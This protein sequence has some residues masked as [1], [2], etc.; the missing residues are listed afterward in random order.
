MSE[1]GETVIKS[2]DIKGDDSEL[3]DI[4]P[5]TTNNAAEQKAE[6]DDVANERGDGHEEEQEGG[7]TE[8]QEK[9]HGEKHEEE[10][11]QE[12]DAAAQLQN[13]A[14]EDQDEDD[15]EDQEND[16]EEV[17]RCLC[18]LAQPPDPDNQGYIQCD[19]CAV[20]QHQ[21]CLGISPEKGEE[22]EKYW[23]EQCKPELHTVYDLKVNRRLA[24]KEPGDSLKRSSYN[25]ELQKQTIYVEKRRRHNRNILSNSAENSPADENDPNED[26][27]D[28]DKSLNKRSLGRMSRKRGKT[29]SIRS[30]SKDSSLR[31]SRNRSS[32]A[33]REEMEYQNILNKVLQESKKDA[34]KDAY[35]NEIVG[36]EPETYSE[37][38]EKTTEHR[39]TKRRRVASPKPEQ[40]YAFED[41]QQEEQSQSPQPKR[42][43]RRNT[44]KETE[45]IDE[46]MEKDNADHSKPEEDEINIELS[47]VVKP[48]R[49]YNR[50]APGAPSSNGKKN[51]TRSRGKQALNDNEN[52]SNSQKNEEL[53][54]NQ[55]QQSHMDKLLQLAQELSK[56]R[57]TPEGITIQEMVQRSSAM[58]EF[59]GR[60]T[61]ELKSLSKQQ[62]A[63]LSFVENEQFINEYHRDVNISETLKH[64]DKLTRDLM[65][66]QQSK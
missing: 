17:T 63:L 62:S 37:D 60:S 57:T 53:L 1:T 65:S 48:K 38:P 27:I 14:Q 35:G 50:R 41:S 32:A 31:G 21:A 43:Y 29:T 66:F 58:L 55:G 42:H 20:W 3:K 44:A 49:S 36:D 34:Y 22:L 54:E 59:L 11:E 13:E 8:A 2:G 7:R 25:W 4:S 40:Q 5:F 28:A 23:C 26:P 12:Q 61:E 18:S 15:E 24:S 47:P 45:T 46:I 51:N 56:P 10:D 52:N 39:R 16:G 64:M 6:Y 9:E 19:S 33:E 30:T